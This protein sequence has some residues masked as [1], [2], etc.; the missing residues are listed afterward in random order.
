MDDTETVI[1]RPWN[2]QSQ[3]FT[4]ALRDEPSTIGSLS[5]DDF[6]LVPRRLQKN[7]FYHSSILISMT[8]Y[9][10]SFLPF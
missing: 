8:F 1:L 2:I 3:T 9:K 4:K 6:E 7:V 5:N 10:E